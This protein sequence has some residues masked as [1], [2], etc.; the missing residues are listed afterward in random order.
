MSAEQTLQLFYASLRITLPTFGWVMLGLFL[1]RVGVFP[2]WLNDRLSRFGF[3]I[4]LPLMLFCGAA[5]VD[6]TTVAASRYLL[7]GILATLFVFVV[8]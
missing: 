6:Y 5:L 8:S 4:G 1:H 7:A 2:A 3:N